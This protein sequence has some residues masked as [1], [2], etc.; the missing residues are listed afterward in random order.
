V[1]PRVKIGTRRSQLALWQANFVA[2]ALTR[3]GIS[4]EIIG[5]TTTGDANQTSP[6][7]K[8][9]GKGVFVK[10][11]E[12]ALLAGE[13]D[14]AVHSMKDVPM[15][16]P[17]GLTMGAVCV[18]ENPFDA[19]VADAAS[20]GATLD[21]LGDGARIGTSSLRRRKQLAALYPNLEYQDI[22]GNVDTRL[23]K[24]DDGGF[25]GIILAVA[26]LKRLDLGA[27]ISEELDQTRCIPAI[28]Q[29]AV[30]I[31]CRDEPQSLALIEALNDTDTAIC[32]Q[33]ERAVGRA[34]GATCDVPLGAYA[35]VSG[36][37]LSLTGYLGLNGSGPVRARVSG[38]RGDGD[39]LGAALARQLMA[40]D[41]P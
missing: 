6:L 13:I 17:D 5:I 10:E 9:G 37:T 40:S 14:L 15:S 38:R 26:A 31:E 28:G 8:I 19:F 27:R 30:G 4:H 36:D 20:P 2:D 29:G 24:L 23:R 41:A 3:R 21:V 25:D 39:D 18:R 34:L 12:A 16:L 32:V 35:T 7:S 22:R 1:S 11:I 33:A